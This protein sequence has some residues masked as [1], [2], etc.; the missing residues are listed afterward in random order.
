M[1]MSGVTLD[2]VCVTLFKGMQSKHDAKFLGF[3]ISDDGK[4]IV[5]D[6][7][8]KGGPKGTFAEF[9]KLVTSKRADVPR[10]FLVDMEVTAKSGAATTKLLFIYWCPDNAPVKQKMLYASSKDTI[11]KQFTGVESEL[12]ATE[13]SELTEEEGK[14][15]LR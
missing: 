6:D 2:P 1:A 12:Q 3:K 5:P 9:Q 13:P 4:K 11:R 8:I 15:K 10:Y 14:K 7:E